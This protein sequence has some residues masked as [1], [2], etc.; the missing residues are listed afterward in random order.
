[1][2]GGARC[3]DAE[4]QNATTDIA[5]LKEYRGHNHFTNKHQTP[6]TF[7]LTATIANLNP[8][9]GTRIRTLERS[10]STNPT[11]KMIIGA[12]T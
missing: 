9:A 7:P 11:R 4:P 10:P 6:S 1:M 8:M 2:I 5:E 3:R 12:A